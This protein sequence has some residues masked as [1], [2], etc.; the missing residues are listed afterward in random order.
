MIFL[1]DSNWD[2]CRFEKA[3]IT[4]QNNYP[5]LEPKDRC[6]G[7]DNIA[8]SPTLSASSQDLNL[9]E[10]FFVHIQLS[11]LQ[12]SRRWCPSK[13]LNCK[14][15]QNNSLK[16]TCLSELKKSSLE[17]NSVAWANSSTELYRWYGKMDF[18][19]GASQVRKNLSNPHGGQ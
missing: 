19:N 7:A 3:H 6:R 5:K 17:G 1:V 18:E 4:C 8:T 14:T 15:W 2:D 12:R 11:I 13:M 16:I 9:A 10:S